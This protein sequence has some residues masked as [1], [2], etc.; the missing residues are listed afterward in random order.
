MDYLWILVAYLLGAIPFA[1]IVG[2]VWHDTDIR[3]HGSG[4]LGTT[5]TFRTLGKKAGLIVFICDVLKG[6]IAVWLPLLFDLS[7][8]P[9]WFGLA[10]VLGH[11]YSVYIR[12][13]GGKAVATSAGVLLVLDPVLFVSGIAV[14][15]LTLLL[16]K[17]VSLSSILAAIYGG[18]HSVFFSE[19]MVMWMVLLLATVIVYR[20]KTNIHRIFKGEEEKITDFLKKNTNE[21]S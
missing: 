6:S 19:T 17:M 1:L 2:K 13:Q 5:N 18:I 20:H 15:F 8:E 21:R 7:I 10:A 16:F 14:F 3:A 12:F 9:I 4:N 11:C